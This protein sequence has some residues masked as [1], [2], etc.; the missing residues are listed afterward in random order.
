MVSCFKA[1]FKRA[2][3]SGAQWAVV[4]GS[5][6]LQSESVTVKPLRKDQAQEQ[7]KWAELA[8]RLE[9]WCC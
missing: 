8:A 7:V 2:D 9:Q 5:D 1:Q 6:E 4:I 3:R